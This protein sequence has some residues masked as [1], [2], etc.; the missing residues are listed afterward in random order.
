[1]KLNPEQLET[2]RL[3]LSKVKIYYPDIQ[4][5]LL[6]HVAS[7]TEQLMQEGMDFDT[8]FSKAAQKVNPQKFQMDVLIASHLSKAKAIFKSF[9]EPMILIKSLLLASLTLAV[10]HGLGFDIPFAIK[11][12]KASF[13][14]IGA[15]LMLTSFKIKALNNSKLVASWNSAWLIFCL[16]L[17]ITNFGLLLALGFDPQIILV[18]TTVYLSFLFVSGF[19]LTIREV[20][21]LKTA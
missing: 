17:P 5:E 18:F 10:V 4:D 7:E 11:L 13:V 12:L 2:I 3:E 20:Q 8:A 6:D 19:T 14:G 15:V 21:K 9:I 1:M 16:F